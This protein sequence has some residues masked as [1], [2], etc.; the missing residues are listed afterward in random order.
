MQNYPRQEGWSKILK[1]VFYQATVDYLE[2]KD[3]PSLIT[4]AVMEWFLVSLQTKVLYDLYDI[5]VRPKQH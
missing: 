5:F 4:M 2:M 1:G 3:E